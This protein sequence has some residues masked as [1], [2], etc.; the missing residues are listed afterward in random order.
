MRV[1]ETPWEL[2]QRLK[3]AICEA[4]MKLTDGRHREWFIALLMPHLRIAL[5]QQKIGTQAKSLEIF[6]R[7]HDTPIQ[8]ATLGEPLPGVV[9]FEKRERR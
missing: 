2:D 3:F 8:D 4:N 7:L 9:E 1:D 6:M 5:S